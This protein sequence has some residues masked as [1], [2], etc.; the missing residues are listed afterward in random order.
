MVQLQ[1]K[2]YCAFT[3]VTPGISAMVTDIINGTQEFDL[4]TAIDEEHPCKRS[5]KGCSK[6]L[7]PYSPLAFLDVLRTKRSLAATNRGFLYRNRRMYRTV[8]NKV[9]PSYLYKKRIV[10]PNH[11]STLMLSEL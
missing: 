8:M 2:T 7:N 1:P 3:K 9:G 4:A 5:T 6:R 10:E 11:T